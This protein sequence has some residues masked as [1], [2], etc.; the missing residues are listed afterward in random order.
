MKVCVMR[1]TEKKLVSKHCL[2]S[3]N[4]T[5]RAGRVQFAP[6]F[7]SQCLFLLSGGTGRCW[8]GTNALLT[9]ISSF[10]PV[11][12]S[13]AVLASRMLG[14]EVTSR[15]RVERPFSSRSERTF[16]L[17]AVAITCSPRSF[18]EIETGEEEQVYE[19]LE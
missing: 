4:G 13:T 18:L 19:P 1:I 15:L 10:P 2:A 7:I 5:S 6:L 17:R 11:S 14:S 9:K 16:L 12:F 8:R 3:D